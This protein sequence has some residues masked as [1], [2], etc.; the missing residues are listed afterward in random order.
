MRYH[1]T[2]VRNVIALLCVAAILVCA[3]TP[4]APG[5]LLA[6]LSPIWLFVAAIVVLALL[7]PV[8]NPRLSPV[9]FFSVFSSRPPPVS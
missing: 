9:P 1:G 6:L 8:I 3:F 2:T 5:L 4:G 7:E